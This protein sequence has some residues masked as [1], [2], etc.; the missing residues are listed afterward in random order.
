[1]TRAKL[2]LPYKRLS[3]RPGY[4]N[5]SKPEKIEMTGP[6]VKEVFKDGRKIKFHT[7]RK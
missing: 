3:S 1:M 2:N 5:T 6:V 7:T 4:L